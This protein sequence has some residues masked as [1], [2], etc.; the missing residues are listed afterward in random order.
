MFQGSF[1]DSVNKLLLSA[2]DVLDIV[3]GTGDRAPTTRDKHLCPLGICSLVG[4]ARHRKCIN[5]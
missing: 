5:T 1:T 3:S 2:C 4:K